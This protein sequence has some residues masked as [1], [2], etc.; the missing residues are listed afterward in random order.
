MVKFS[1]DDDFLDIK[2]LVTHSHNDLYI[3]QGRKVGA[4]PANLHTI[5][6]DMQTQQQSSNKYHP[7]ILENEVVQLS[8]SN[9][10]TIKEVS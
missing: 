2:K 3:E 7:F 4:A 8:S 10:E 6:K 5:N 1:I 9:H